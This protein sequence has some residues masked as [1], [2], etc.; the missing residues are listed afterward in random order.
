MIRRFYEKID[1]G[2]APSEGG[3]DTLAHLLPYFDRDPEARFLDI[4]CYDGSLTRA[5]WEHSQAREAQGVDFLEERLQEAR[6][7]GI[8]AHSVDLN[9]DAPLP[10]SDG[11]FD[12]IFCGEVIEHLFSPDYLLEEIFRLLKPGGYVVLTTPNLASWRNRVSLLLGWQPLG[13]EV[14]TRYRVGHPRAPQGHPSGH[15]RLF[16][17]RALRELA[18]RYGFA[19]ERLAG[20]C[21]SASSVDG[22]ARVAG[23]LDRGIARWLPSWCDQIVLKARKPPRT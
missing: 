7:H 6:Q 4:G 12:F 16:T 3:L 19:V 22:I 8:L 5:I 21:L 10:F 15:L 11:S 18:P 9:Q 2:K 17:P 13:S 1:T 23:A 20:Y 14:S